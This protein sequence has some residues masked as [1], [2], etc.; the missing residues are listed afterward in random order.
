[1]L[2]RACLC[3][4]AFVARVRAHASPVSVAPKMITSFLAGFDVTL[5]TRI[6]KHARLCTVLV[7]LAL[8]LLVLL[9]LVLL[10]LPQLLHA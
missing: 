5:G 10:V 4:C 1:M 3:E 7:L 6:S 8:V 9:V 2:A